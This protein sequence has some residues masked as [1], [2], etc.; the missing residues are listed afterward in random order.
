MSSIDFDELRRIHRQEKGSQQLAELGEDFMVELKAYL[1]EKKE[2]YVKRLSAGE[3]PSEDFFNIQRMAKE[4]LEIRQKKIIKKAF[5]AAVAEED[6][7]DE[8]L[9]EDE[10]KLFCN[11]CKVVSEYQKSIEKIFSA[12]QKKKKKDSNLNTIS[13]QIIEEVPAFVGPNMKEFGPYKKGQ[14]V[15]LPEDVADILLSRKIAVKE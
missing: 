11:I 5:H 3:A 8:K 12:E 6:V 10:K 2:E 15:D 4:I 14:I 9:T 1:E 13:V 7:E